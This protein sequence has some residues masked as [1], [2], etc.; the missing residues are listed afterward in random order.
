MDIRTS[1]ACLLAAESFDAKVVFCGALPIPALAF[2]A[3]QGKRIGVYEHY[4]VAHDMIK[5][6]PRVVLLQANYISLDMSAQKSLFFYKKTYFY[7][8]LL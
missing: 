3:I 7:S 6:Y 4:S 1:K 2:Y 5:E 8:A